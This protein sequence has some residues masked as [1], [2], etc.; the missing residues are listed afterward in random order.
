MRA[1]GLV[2]G[3]KFRHH[4]RSWLALSLVITLVSGVVLAAAAAGRR[5]DSAFSRFVSSHGY[6]VIVYSG[7]PLPQL[8]RWPEVA[9][10]TPDPMPFYGHLRCGC[11]RRIDENDF[12]L[13]E[14]PPAGLGRV[15]KLVAGRMPDQSAPDE[16]LASFTLERD[17]GVHIGTVIRIPLYAPSQRQAA[18]ASLAGGAAPRP[19]GPTVALRVVGIAVAENEFPSGQTPTYDVYPTSAFAA[20]NRATPALSA[21]YVRLRHGQASFSRFEARASALGEPGLEDLDRPA[22]AIAASIH[23]QAVGWWVLCALAALAGIAVLGQALARQATTDSA[24]YPTLTALGMRSRELVILGMLRTLIAGIAG[25]A[26]GIAL[27]A[28]LSRFAPAGEARLADPA[29]GPAFDARVLLSGALATV[30]ITLALG[31]PPALR[32]ARTRR[33]AAGP[34]AVRPSVVVSIVAAAG[35]SASAVIGTRHALVRGRGA[36]AV[37]V[38]IA[39]TGA[40]TAV[41]ALVATAVFGASLSYLTASPELYGAPFQAYFASSG[42]GSAAENSLLTELR[43][44]PAIDRITLAAVPAIAVNHTSVRAVAA[45]PIRGPILLSAVNG[46]LP[47]SDDEVALGASTMRRV[48]ARVGSV[49]R[50]TVTSPGGAA[51]GG[52]YRVVGLVSFPSDL[53]TGGLGTGAALTIAGYI[54]AQCPAGPARPACRRA[55]ERGLQSVIL[56][57]AAP[58]PAGSAALAR[59]I[60]KHPGDAYRPEVP[61]ALVSFG[62]SANFP[63][64]LGAVLVLCGTAALAHLLIVSVSR[65][66]RESGLLKTLG[67]VRR[68]VATI[69]LWQATTVAIVGI[70]AGVPLGIAAGQAIWRAFAISLG[71]VAVPVVPGLLIGALAAGVLFAANAIAIVPA[72]AASRSRPGQLLRTE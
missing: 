38:G 17:N 6:D 71:V 63:L 24:D 19:Q 4:W 62:E 59:H 10:V 68:Q 1:I 22:A 39:L 45:T 54:G 25:A 37:P 69:V 49:V 32:S 16:A 2:L 23:P 58:G 29:P 66:R 72:L 28:L 51:R 7:R 11:P 3:A 33:P 67:F 34:P 52:R 40:V 41:L 26:G 64:L 20:A 12:T 56:A 42:P 43:S 60:R 30:A 46:R 15:V 21:Y 14:V 5:T 27:A 55:A 36:R 65:R 9:Q 8:A 48:G 13:R 18:F 53:G 31:V 44:D 70:A 61:A 57:H 35:A 47:A 50:I